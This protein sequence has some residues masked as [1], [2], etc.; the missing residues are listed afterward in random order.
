MVGFPTGKPRNPLNKER[1]GTPHDQKAK[2]S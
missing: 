1:L 2:Q